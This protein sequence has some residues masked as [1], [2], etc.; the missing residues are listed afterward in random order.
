MSLFFQSLKNR[1]KIS[2][3]VYITLYRIIPLPTCVTYFLN[4]PLNSECIRILH[5]IVS[6]CERLSTK[7]GKIIAMVFKILPVWL[8]IMLKIKQFYYYGTN[9]KLK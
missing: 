9:E 4:G 1:V 6:A 8:I 3:K 2:E 7:S 5:F